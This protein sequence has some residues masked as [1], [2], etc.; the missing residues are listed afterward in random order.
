LGYADSSLNPIWTNSLISGAVTVVPATTTSNLVGHFISGAA[1]LNDTA[2]YVAPGLYYGVP[3][4]TTSS[5]QFYYFTNDVPPNATAGAQSLYI[6]NDAIAITN[7][8]SSDSDYVVDTFDG[9]I[10]NAFT[11]MS[12]VKGNGGS[13]NAFVTKGGDN[14]IGWALRTGSASTTAC[15]TLRGT[16]QTDDMQAGG[17]I[18]DSNWHFIAGTYDTVSGNRILYVDG[19][20]VASETG[21][22]AYT[23]NPS[24]HLTLG[25]EDL[26]NG[27]YGNNGYFSGKMFDVRIYNYALTQSQITNIMANPGGQAAAPVVNKPGV[28]NGQLVFTWTGSS[29]LEATNILGPWTTVAG[30]SSPYTNSVTASPQMFF[31][32]IQ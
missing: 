20:N 19:V 12:W 17:A 23:E 1:N 30:A 2:N 27:S 28:I 5:S 24:G 21:N 8:S 29:L 4:Q 14:G 32:A 6:Q 3:A 18:P 13:W 31:K 26:G 16:S 7:T 22:T 9:G 25:T 15:W 10:A 11:V